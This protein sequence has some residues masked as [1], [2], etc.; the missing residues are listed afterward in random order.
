MGANSGRGEGMGKQGIG[1]RQMLKGMG[2]GTLGAVAA[3]GAGMTPVLAKEDT[4]ASDARVE[5]SWQA[6]IHVE[7]PLDK[8]AIFPAMFGFARGGPVSR[9]DGRDN[10]PSMGGKG[11][12]RLHERDLHRI[13]WNH[14][15][16]VRYLHG[17]PP[18]CQRTVAPTKPAASPVR[19]AGRGA[20]RNHRSSDHVRAPR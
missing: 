14:L 7:Q 17:G 11:Q 10:S 15:F 9:V 2:A 3:L 13:C 1:R 5:G 19:E 8:A 6:V 20:Q 16:P 4:D 12:W 18:P